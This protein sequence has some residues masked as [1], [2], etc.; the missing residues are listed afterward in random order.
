MKEKE[1]SGELRVLFPVKNIDL[2]DGTKLVVRPLSLEDLPHVVK[3]FGSLVT[4]FETN[5]KKGDKKVSNA[6]IASAAT[7]QLLEILPYC[8]D[9]PASNIPMTVVPEVLET[10]IDQNV[11]DL[12]VGKW[13]ALAKRAMAMLPSDAPQSLSTK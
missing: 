10:I 5:V 4:I 7:A 11:T 12:A 1:N 6:E 13:M 9:R 2:A 8:I 3:A